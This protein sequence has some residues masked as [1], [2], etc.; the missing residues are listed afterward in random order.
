M[1]SKCDKQKLVFTRPPEEKQTTKKGEERREKPS[2]VGETEGLPTSKAWSTYTYLY[3]PLFTVVVKTY[4]AQAGALALVVV[5]MTSAKCSKCST[6]PQLHGVFST[7][8]V[9]RHEHD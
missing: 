4:E 3:T 2:A 7:Q 5:A 1:L 6:A 8:D 9:L